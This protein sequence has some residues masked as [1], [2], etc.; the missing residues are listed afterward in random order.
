MT[1]IF[2]CPGTRE[3][4]KPRFPASRDP[5]D[6]RSF[7]TF[8]RSRTS[9]LPSPPGKAAPPQR[10]CLFFKSL[11]FVASAPSAPPEAAVGRGKRDPG[12]ASAPGEDVRVESGSRRV[13]AGESITRNGFREVRLHQVPGTSRAFQGRRGATRMMHRESISNFGGWPRATFKFVL[14]VRSGWDVALWRS[15]STF[16]GFFNPCYPK[17]DTFSLFKVISYTIL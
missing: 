14:L 11:V 15:F 3:F 12:H 8:H 17:L 6:A 1:Y 4:P 13:S 16:S 2:H 7:P 5:L 10:E 9:P